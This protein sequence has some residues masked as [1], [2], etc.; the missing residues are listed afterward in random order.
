LIIPLHPSLIRDC[1]AMSKN[2]IIVILNPSPVILNEVKNLCLRLRINS[3]K[4][5]K[6]A[7]GY[8]LEILRLM[9]QNDITAQSLRGGITSL[10]P[11]RNNAPLLCSGVRF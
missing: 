1:V 3:A 6:N 2:P 4:N 8:K 7:K 5:L 9:P 11:V 10:Y